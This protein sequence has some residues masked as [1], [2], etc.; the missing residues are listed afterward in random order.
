ME[1]EGALEIICGLKNSLLLTE[2]ITRCKED[3]VDFSKSFN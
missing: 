2:E 3:G 1:L